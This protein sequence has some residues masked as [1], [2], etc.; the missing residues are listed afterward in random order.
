MTTIYI[1][2]P[3]RVSSVQLSRP[4]KVSNIRRYKTVL[5]I[6]PEGV[7]IRRAFDLGALVAGVADKH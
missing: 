5:S 3:A 2:G 4:R 1:A 7:Q 6:L